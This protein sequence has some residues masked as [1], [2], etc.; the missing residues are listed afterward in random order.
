M[1]YDNVESGEWVQPTRDGYRMRCCD[2]GL[3]HR[4]DF[5]LVSRGLGNNI[6][7]RMFRDN[8]ATAAS[9]RVR[10]LASARQIR[11]SVGVTKSDRRFAK[12]AARWR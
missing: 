5:R 11:R 4:V 3:V 10:K 9:R 1:K 7:F 6:L 2:C 12:I 8:R